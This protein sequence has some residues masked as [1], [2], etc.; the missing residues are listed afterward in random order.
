MR[1]EYIGKYKT[2]GEIKNIYYSEEYDKFYTTYLNLENMN[3]I[4]TKIFEITNIE[5]IEALKI[6]YRYK[7]EY[8]QK[9]EEE[10]QQ[11]LENILQENRKLDN[12][13][14]S[15]KIAMYTCIYIVISIFLSLKKP[16]SNLI[17]NYRYSLIDE[18]TDDE[19]KQEI[20]SKILE[21]LTTNKTISEETKKALINNFN[22]LIFTDT[23]LFPYQVDKII[24]RIENYNFNDAVKDNNI[25]TLEYIIFGKKSPVYKGVIYSLDDYANRHNPSI[26]TTLF[27]DL[28]AAYSG[29]ILHFILIDGE[30]GYIKELASYYQTEMSNIEEVLNLLD[31]YD[32]CTTQK[33]K[34]QIIEL[35]YDK[36]SRILTNYYKGKNKLTELDR[37][38]LACQIYKEQHILTNNLFS[39]NISVSYDNEEYG[40][41]KRYY[42]R[43]F[44]HEISMSIYREKLV[45]LIQ[46][47]GNNLDIKDPDSRFLTH[48]YL[49]CYKDSLTYYNKDLVYCQNSEKLADLFINNIFDD[50]GSTTF[51]PE[52][53]YSYFTNRNIN[54]HNLISEIG[55]NY[56]FSHD[57]LEIALYVEYINCLKKDCTDPEDQSTLERRLKTV[58]HYGEEIYNLILDYSRTNQ[59][60][61]TDFKILPIEQKY[62]D[63]KIKKYRIEQQK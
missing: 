24:N 7:K 13:R 17:S 22:V 61:F 16:V 58:A 38:I 23:P 37:N 3:D 62:T 1:Y 41:Y 48:L 9:K 21:A 52:F 35:Y 14:I 63:A 46:E 53:M 2:N 32:Q 33:E 44:G 36:L 20:Y 60:L 4:I 50:E 39:N 47:K 12:R 11:E 30:K 15:R 54:I 59:S 29:N 25:E 45:K 6:A 40:S 8:D 49:L 57:T 51:E 10:Y 34:E 55:L 26:K 27:G 5:E 42:N 19:N 18:V 31:S 56:L 43:T 28:S